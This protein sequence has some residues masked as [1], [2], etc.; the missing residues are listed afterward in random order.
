MMSSNMTGAKDRTRCGL[1]LKYTAEFDG[2]VTQLA[3]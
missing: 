3:K 2:F 1:T